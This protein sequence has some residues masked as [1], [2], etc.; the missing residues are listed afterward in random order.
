MTD[1]GF[2]GRL[3]L[4]VC[5]HK[6]HRRI[7]LSDS[8]RRGLL[9][10]RLHSRVVFGVLVLISATLFV[11][12]IAILRDH[13]ASN[14]V[15]LSAIPAMTA[16]NEKRLLS[17]GPS[18]PACPPAGLPALQPSPATGHH[19]V[20]LT[21]H[22]SAPAANGSAAVGYCLYRSKT[23]NAAKLN[24]R[25]SDCEPINPVPIV[26]TGC[27]DDL[28]EDSA[29]YYYVVTAINAKGEISSSS[30]ETP[31]QVPPNKAKASSVA[32]GS[33]PLCRAVT[34]SQPA[35]GPAAP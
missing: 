28:V 15:S 18:L 1:R 26:G 13:P 7:R 25:C 29:A 2:A 23:Q 10:I 31:A 35:P 8:P 24:P 21:W 32:V 19:K 11:A 34:A 12:T 4:L 5:G 14:R 17:V 6:Y 22:A 20:T 16:M 9:G 3:R 30:N 27:V 33:Y